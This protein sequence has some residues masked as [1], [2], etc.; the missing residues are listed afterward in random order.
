MF[1]ERGNDRREIV[2]FQDDD[3][4]LA[5]F[6]MTDDGQFFRSGVVLSLAERLIESEPFGAF[7]LEVDILNIRN[8]IG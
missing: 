6:P 7:A 8:N 2:E 4:G 5:V 3:P 1:V